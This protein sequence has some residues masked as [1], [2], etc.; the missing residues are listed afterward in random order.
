MRG[1]ATFMAERR[2][3]DLGPR[4]RQ[5]RDNARRVLAELGGA[6]SK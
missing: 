1:A 2:G 4:A 5:D 6:Q 3:V